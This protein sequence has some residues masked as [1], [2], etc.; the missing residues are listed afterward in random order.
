MLYSMEQQDCGPYECRVNNPICEQCM[1]IDNSYDKIDPS[2]G[3][4]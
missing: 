2:I 3:T 1:I 4:E